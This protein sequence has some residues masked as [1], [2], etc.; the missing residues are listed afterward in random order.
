VPTGMTITAPNLTTVINST[1]NFSGGAFTT[2]SLEDLDLT[3][4]YVSGGATFS[5]VSATSYNMGI[6]SNVTLSADGA[7][8]VLDMHT[9]QTVTDGVGGSGNN[10][11][12][13][14]NGGTVN[15]SGVTALQN[16]QYNAVLTLQEGGGGTIN[17]NNLQTIG[18]S[19]QSPTYFQIANGYPSATFSLPSLTGANYAQFEV[20]TGMTINAPNLVTAR[21]QSMEAGRSWI[22]T[23]CKPLSM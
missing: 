21:C 16:G 13:A 11:I 4:I 22:C 14:T 7:G 18:Y 3:S 1:I 2:G 10:Y 15:L 5:S 23:R 12:S 9:V 20:P 17:L 19:G 6:N 8:S